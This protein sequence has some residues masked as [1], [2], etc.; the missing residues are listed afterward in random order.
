[1][2]GIWFSLVPGELNFCNAKNFPIKIYI[3]FLVSSVQ[4]SD[5]TF[6]YLTIWST[7]KSI[8]HLQPYKIMMLLAIFLVLYIKTYIFIKNYNRKLPKYWKWRKISPTVSP[9]YFPSSSLFFFFSNLPNHSICNRVSHPWHNWHFGPE[10]PL[11]KETVSCTARCLA[12]FL[13]STH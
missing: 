3:F 11:S 9:F 5:L 2:I 7:L 13:T 8:N 4:H 1:M 10:N 6:M 12:A